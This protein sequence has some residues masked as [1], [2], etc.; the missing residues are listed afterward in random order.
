MLRRLSILVVF[1]ALMVGAASA[2]D[3]HSV[4][5]A[6]AKAMGATNLKTIQYSGT[7]FVAA[8]GQ[9][10]SLTDD[11]PRFEVTSY[12]RTI[13]YDAKSARED[14]TRQ[15]GNYPPRGAGFTPLQG[16]ERNINLTS[17]NLA[18]HLHGQTPG[19]H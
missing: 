13:D 17:V 6:A 16:D 11:W 9:S 12:T 8:V 3:A 10:Y 7:G 18:S 14:Y 5:Q 15:Q 4:L 19:P 1:L 2:Q